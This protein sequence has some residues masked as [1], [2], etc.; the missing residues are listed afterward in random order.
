MGPIPNQDGGG[1]GEVGR[2]EEGNLKTQP[3]Q[4]CKIA[5]VVQT[6]ELLIFLGLESSGPVGSLD[7]P[8]DLICR[9]RIHRSHCSKSR[10][11]MKQTH[12]CNTEPI[13]SCEDHVHKRIIKE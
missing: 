13:R 8:K 6:Q 2:K 3:R 12:K 1:G 7:P 5:R 11:E 9:F 10:T 4:K